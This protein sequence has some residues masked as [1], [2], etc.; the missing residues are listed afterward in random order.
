MGEPRLAKPRSGGP[1]ATTRPSP[2]P[3]G[4][5]YAYRSM[6]TTHRWAGL[7]GVGSVYRLAYRIGPSWLRSLGARGPVCGRDWLRARLRAAPIQF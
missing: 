6:F 1:D 7:G 5:M 4:A 3:Y 2:E